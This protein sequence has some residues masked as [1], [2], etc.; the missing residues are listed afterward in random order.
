[1]GI[2][3][4]IYCDIMKGIY[5]CGKNKFDLCN[6]CIITLLYLGS[7]ENIIS[8][9]KVNG[10]YDKDHDFIG[11]SGFYEANPEVS[12]IKLLNQ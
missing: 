2:K 8:L 6:I 10:S 12:I 5:K 11:C 3:Q 1:M 9:K 7:N 4:S